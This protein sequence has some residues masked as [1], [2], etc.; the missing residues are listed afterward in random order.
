M[1]KLLLLIPT[2]DRSGAEKQLTL[3]AARL[4]KT[5]FD[6]RV[7]ALTR[8]GPYKDVLERHGIAC[9][10][11]G[12]RFKFDPFA[13]GRLRK[14]VRD[15]HPDVLHSWLFAANAY[16]RLVA[17]KRDRP[18]VVVSE[19]CVDSWKSGWQLWLDR[20]QI[21][22]T[23]RLVANS[24]SVAE[25]YRGQGFPS[26]RIT[27]IPNGVELPE[28]TEEDRLAVLRELDIPEDSR[29]VGY[30]GRLARQKRVR[31]LVWAMQLLRQLRD[32]IHL[33][34]VGDGPERK[35]VEA[36]A[37]H[38]GCDHLIRFAGHRDDAGRMFA[39]IDVF[40]LA[41]DFEGMSNSLMEAMAAGIP[42]V[43]TDIPPNR[44]LLED[45]KQG[46]V[47]KP[48]DSVGFAQFADRLL[49][50]P[51]LRRRQGEAA[52]QRMRGEFSVEKMVDSYAR[53]Y[54]EITV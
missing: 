12:K 13:L 17:G 37:K 19:R 51:Q 21:R 2:L 30:V 15:E 35:N 7:A 41:S 26:E 11:L 23:H 34:I 47:V 8:G 53:L 42:S 6:V 4:P 31:D 54:R 9:S 46:F 3:L 45:G 29:V 20:R 22:R 50:D 36:F 44:E 27:V 18:R 39:A 43:V 33:L 16:A 49:G 5:E 40:W 10:V 1:I 14:L 52:R 32:R 48:G 38:V 25:F 24:N 28:F